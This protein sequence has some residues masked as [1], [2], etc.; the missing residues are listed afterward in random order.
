MG[1]TMEDTTRNVIIGSVLAGAFAV[2]GIYLNQTAFFE[3]PVPAVEPTAADCPRV[4]AVSLEAPTKEGYVWVPVD[5]DF[6]GDQFVRIAGH[7]ERKR[8]NPTAYSKGHW[9]VSDGRCEWV[10]GA[11][12]GD[13]RSVSGTITVRD[14]R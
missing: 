7:W 3:K 5:F 6:V 2:A 10:R 1:S 9:E 8:A 4:P 14:H 12:V 11:F 13:S